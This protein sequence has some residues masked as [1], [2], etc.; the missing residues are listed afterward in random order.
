M[1]TDIISPH[2]CKTQNLIYSMFSIPD[3]FTRVSR[4]SISWNTILSSV[5]TEHWY[6]KFYMKRKRKNDQ[7]NPDK[8]A[9]LPIPYM[10]VRSYSFKTQVKTLYKFFLEC[11]TFLEGAK[12][13]R[14]KSFRRFFSS[15]LPF[16][17]FLAFFAL[18]FFCTSGLADL[19]KVQSGL[20]R[21]G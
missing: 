19:H 20:A 11:Q 15:L 13:I 2:I 3:E 1:F 14:S 12:R 18:Y 4:S 10:L 21:E 17:L 5:L 8:T 7:T 16:F 9:E 6:F